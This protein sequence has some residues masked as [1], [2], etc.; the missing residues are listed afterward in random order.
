M[1][2][3]QYYGNHTPMV[4]ATGNIELP[5]TFAWVCFE[6]YICVSNVSDF[7]CICFYSST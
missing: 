5:A 6:N 3:C 7:I 1:K 2:Q 4:A